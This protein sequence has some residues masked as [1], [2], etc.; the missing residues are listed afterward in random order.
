MPVRHSLLTGSLVLVLMAGCSST[1]VRPKPGPLPSLPAAPV[2]LQKDWSVR[3][4]DGA[5]KDDVVSLRPAVSAGMTLVAGINGVL[6]SVDD[7]GKV[8][9]RD[10]TGLT[11]TGGLSAGYG[12]VAAGTTK[13][14]AA[15]WNI[16][17]GKQLWKVN[18]SAAVLSPPVQTQDKVIFKTNDGKVA[19]LDPV[20]GKTVWTYD[21]PVPALSLRGYAPPLLDND[22]L[23]V[24]TAVGKVVAIEAAT[25]IGQWE[26]QVVSPK[27]RSEIERLVD[28]NG[29]MLVTDDKKLLVAGY[30]GQLSALDI[31]DRPDPLWDMDASTL[32]GLSAGDDKVFLAD[33]DGKVIAVDIVTGK[34]IWKQEAL[35]W[36]S[37]S[38]TVFIGGRVLVGD[39]QGYLH[40]L[41]ASDGRIIG[42]AR[43]S[44]A[45]SSLT[46][47]NGKLLAATRSGSVSRWSLPSASQ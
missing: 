45:V 17:D 30:Q 31:R 10:K 41:S 27:G 20:S 44:G 9:W 25:G 35:A 1:P 18:L 33:A 13:G 19:A 46:L 23:L 2:Q 29:D 15:L 42:R 36:R 14:E 26:A 8:L 32:Q 5:L 38:N 43:V 34:A 37:L 7:Q 28:I 39:E 12:R 6:Q 47:V 16:A 3:A 24:P 22:L 40:V 4:G 11:L 21:T